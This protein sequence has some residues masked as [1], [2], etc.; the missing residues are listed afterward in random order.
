VASNPAW[1]LPGKEGSWLGSVS[2]CPEEGGMGGKGSINNP[3]DIT[4]KSS[5]SV[6]D[7]TEY[8]EINKINDTD[9]PEG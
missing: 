6:T 3:D 2:E 1:K 4:W 7:K 9:K 8:D 5:P